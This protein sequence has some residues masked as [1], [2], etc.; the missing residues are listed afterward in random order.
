MK[1][2]QRT[3]ITHPIT[4]NNVNPLKIGNKISKK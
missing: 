2:K 3:E 4:K 1:L